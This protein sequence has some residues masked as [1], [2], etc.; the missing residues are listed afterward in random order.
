MLITAQWLDKLVFYWNTVYSVFN[1]KYSLLFTNSD[2]SLIHQYHSW[3]VSN[4]Y[5]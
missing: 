4:T 5:I 3:I 2:Y 1:V